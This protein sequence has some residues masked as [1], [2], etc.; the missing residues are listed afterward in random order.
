MGYLSETWSS[1]Q[2]VLVENVAHLVSREVLVV[3]PLFGVQRIKQ[4]ALHVLYNRINNTITL[5][6]RLFSLQD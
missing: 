4:R 5:N 6:Y 3:I 1:K 2:F